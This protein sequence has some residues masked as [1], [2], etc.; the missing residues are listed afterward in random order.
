MKR[1]LCAA[2]IGLV[3]QSLRSQA[4]PP[5]GPRLTWGSVDVVLVPDSAQGLEI[6][7]SVRERLRG[8][9]FS[10]MTC[11]RF[12]PADVRAWADSTTPLLDSIPG[13]A[14]SLAWIHPPLLRGLDGG[15]VELVRRRTGTDWQS[16]IFFD[17]IRPD[18]N[19]IL[20]LEV[21]FD[22]PTGRSFVDSIRAGAARSRYRPRGDQ[23]VAWADEVDER[24]RLL[25]QP[26]PDV[27]DDQGRRGSQGHAWVQLVVD[28]NGAVEPGPRVVLTDAF[29]YMA[30]A[31]KSFAAAKF[32]PGRL[33]GRKVRTAVCLPM[34]FHNL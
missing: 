33:G 29:R 21:P 10:T 6:W 9:D 3:P 14:D 18:S 22:R 20:P 16:Q 1:L 25:S 12:D 11:A 27:P 28:T 31:L 13:P 15:F 23:D 19:V 30:P 34:A 24:P 5:L 17:Y 2:L 7:L 26:V 32:N 4:P 8:H